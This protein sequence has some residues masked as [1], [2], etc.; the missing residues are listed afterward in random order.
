MKYPPTDNWERKPLK[1]PTAGD[2]VTNSLNDWLS[3][4]WET[5]DNGHWHGSK[6]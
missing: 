5:D 1:I 6:K 2:I 3:N 4:K